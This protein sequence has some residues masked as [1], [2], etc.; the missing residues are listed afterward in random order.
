MEGSLIHV[1]A[2]HEKKNLL[3]CSMR[4]EIDIFVSQIRNYIIS[5]CMHIFARIS[6]LF[7]SK[8]YKY[9]QFKSSYIITIMSMRISKQEHEYGI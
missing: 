3:S 5:L 7:I 9:V 1:E 2:R 4:R 6:R 8:I